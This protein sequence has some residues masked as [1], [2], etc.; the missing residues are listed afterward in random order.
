MAALRHRMMRLR[1]E[2]ICGNHVILFALHIDRSSTSKRVLLGIKSR[3]LSSF[4]RRSSRGPPPSDKQVHLAT[5]GTQPQHGV[6]GGEP[7]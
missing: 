6:Y 7:T 2:T 3:A 4:K 1:T 5:A